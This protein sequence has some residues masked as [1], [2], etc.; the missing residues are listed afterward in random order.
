MADTY[1]TFENFSGEDIN[2]LLKSISTG[3]D[4]RTNVQNNTA[5]IAALKNNEINIVVNGGTY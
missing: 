2:N 5:F 3:G 1:Y 4:I